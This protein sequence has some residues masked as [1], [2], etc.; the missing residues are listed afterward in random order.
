MRSDEPLTVHRDPPDETALAGQFQRASGDAKPETVRLPPGLYAG[1]EP[2][3][4][5]D[6]F[7]T[8]SALYREAIR[9]LLVACCE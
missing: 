8:R 9:K 1:V 4:E 2:L 7:E 6:V 5:E 3:V